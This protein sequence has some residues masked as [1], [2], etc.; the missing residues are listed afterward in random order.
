MVLA[1]AATVH[2]NAQSVGNYSDMQVRLTKSV[3]SADDSAAF[4]V[5]GE[6]RVRQLFDKTGF[7]TSNRNVT[8]NQIYVRQRVPDLFAPDVMD[9]AA[10]DSVLSEVEALRLAN[11]QHIALK[12]ERHS[13]YLG[14]TRT[15]NCEPAMAFPLILNRVTKRFGDDE[16]Q[17][18]EI[19]LGKPE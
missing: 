17:V 16:E 13:R 8:S 15:V 2:V 3:L 9:A 14:V 5:V 18:W 1:L 12:T 7:Y 19:F 6:Q 4:R 11:P 10:I